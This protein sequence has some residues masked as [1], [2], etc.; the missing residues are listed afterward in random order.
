MRIKPSQS[1]ENR[2]EFKTLRSQ[3][4]D[5]DL[6][7]RPDVQRLL[8]N[9][10]QAWSHA[11]YSSLI[12]RLKLILEEQI[13]DGQ[14][15]PDAF[16]PYGPLQL[17][18]QGRLHLLDQIDGTPFLIDPNKL[19]TGMIVL[20]PQGSGKSRFIRHLCKQL[21]E[22]KPETKIT[23]L[24]L[25]GGFSCLQGFRHVDL[26]GMSV[27]LAQP[28]NI[29][30]DIFIHELMPIIADT[31]G[32]IYGLD[33]LRRAVDICLSQLRIYRQAGGA[34]NICLR[35]ILQAL[36]IIKVSHFREVGYLDASRTA[37]SLIVGRHGLFSCRRALSLD[38]LFSSNTVINA[39][40]LTHELQ[41]K[42]LAL[43]LL[44]WLYQRARNNP[45]FK[46]LKHLLIIDDATRFIGVANQFSGQNKTS[47]LGHLLAILRS[48]GVGCIFATQLPAQVDPA[49][50]SL[51]RSMI[52]VGNVNGEDHLRVIQSF[53]S[54]TQE[55][56]S[57]ILQFQTREA[58]A[59]VSGCQWPRPVHGFVPFVEDENIGNV[60]RVDTKSMI[61]P[62]HPLTQ[63]PRQEDANKEVEKTHK[64]DAIQIKTEFDRLI[65]DRIQFPYQKVRVLIKRLK[66]PVRNYETA[67]TQAVQEGFMIYSQC[68]KSVYLV[69]TAKAY[70]RFK[71]P[72]PYER[73]TSIEHAFY[74]GLAAHLL[75]QDKNIA[76]VQ[77]E[78]PIGARGQTIDVTAST[79]S[80]EMIAV[81][82]TLST[83]NL[84]SNAAK[85]QDTSY[86]EI[87]WL[88]K[89]AVTAK[90][91]R[92]F[93]NKLRSLPDDLISK[94]RYVHLAKFEKQHKGGK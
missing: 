50:F 42:A 26:S 24:D 27:D 31:A 90:A 79:H 77:Q 19:T 89:D 16:R 92:A 72:C 39:R 68:G 59:F 12:E 49:V 25:K 55:Q 17:L 75:K 43:F 15:R 21:R 46:E 78:T 69:P 18:S 70:Q 2:D 65:Y 36:K 57:A 53:M 73:A 48:T 20:G 88:T 61:V 54:L 67:K 71:T 9:A 8:K 82:V 6:L 52:I 58:L 86:K 83:S 14:R 84:A 76:R 44:F 91:V 1:V 56:K 11:I 64:E 10:D 41:C 38:W 40:C 35:D 5:R 80:G 4:A 30:K 3:L 62:W 63:L 60:Y 37:I 23:V 47:Q 85:L 34:T 81:E 93:F 7:Y 32:L 33:F 45:E 87:I 74:V 28:E 22:I 13:T 51:S 29:T 66:M 94:F